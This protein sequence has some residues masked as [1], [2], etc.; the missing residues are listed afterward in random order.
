MEMSRVIQNYGSREIA[1][2]LRSIL[3]NVAETLEILEVVLSEAVQSNSDDPRPISLP[4]L[5]K[6]TIHDTLLLEQWRKPFADPQVMPR[7]SLSAHCK[8]YGCLSWQFI[9]LCRE[10]RTILN[11]STL[12]W[13]PAG[14]VI[15]PGEPGRRP[16]SRLP[17]SV[18]NVLAKP[19]APPPSGDWSGAPQMSHATFLS[20]LHLLNK[21]DDWIVLLGALG[22]ESWLQVSNKSEWLDRVAGR[23]AGA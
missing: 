12:H 13:S 4:L 23:D 16:S 17:T 7:A 11:A 5:K 2:A 22:N 8:A 1:T 18:Q 21:R 15:R 20:H 10:T 3:E 14:L 6:L 9:R 19:A